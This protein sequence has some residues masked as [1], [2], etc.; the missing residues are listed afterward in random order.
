MRFLPSLRRFVASSLRL[1]V[2]PSLLLLCYL[3]TFLGCAERPQSLNP[4]IPKSLAQQSTRSIQRSVWLEINTFTAQDADGAAILDPWLLPTLERYAACGFDVIITTS[5]GPEYIPIYRALPDQVIGGFKTRN[6]LS[7]L[8]DESG[9]QRI[10]AG[11]LALAE[12]RGVPPENLTIVL[13]N[14]TCLNDFYWY[15][16]DPAG[17]RAVLARR[18][19]Q[20][21]PARYIWYPGFG[22]DGGIGGFSTRNRALLQTVK[23]A[24]PGVRFTDNEFAYLSPNPTWSPQAATMRAQLADKATLS[25]IYTDAFTRYPKGGSPRIGYSGDA[26]PQLFSELRAAGRPSVLYPGRDEAT[27][28]A[29]LWW[30]ENWQGI[31][32]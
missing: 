22:D 2:S 20:L 11:I 26:L 19:S 14:E 4:S 18:L 7:S 12:L 5:P 24:L 6:A 27:C 17:A 30:L 16:R 10:N 3:A 15:S 28:T 23:K 13:E 9:W 29:P 32:N 1:S 31:N 25:I 8:D 21:P